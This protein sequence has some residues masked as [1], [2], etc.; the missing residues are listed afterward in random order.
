MIRD[1]V[2]QD[3]MTR[4]SMIRDSMTPDL[5]DPEPDDPGLDDPGLDQHRRPRRPRAKRTQVRTIAVLGV[6][7]HPH[8]R[9]LPGGRPVGP[10][11]F[12]RT[13]REAGPVRPHLARLAQAEWPA[14][15][16]TRALRLGFR[17]HPP[18]SGLSQERP[19][20]TERRNLVILE[21]VDHLLDEAAGAGEFHEFTP[22]QR[23]RRPI[24]VGL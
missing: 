19:Q 2:S 18:A 6:S 11:Q 5:D 14:R 7:L 16:T 1:Q 24:G 23:P 15:R 4:N 13:A 3:P 22:G 8:I 21:L 20:T 10:P 12:V 17:D 9:R